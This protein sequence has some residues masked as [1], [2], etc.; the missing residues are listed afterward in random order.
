[1]K[2][3]KFLGLISVLSGVC[4]ATSAYGAVS[5]LADG[6]SAGDTYTYEASETFF[7]ELAGLNREFDYVTAKKNGEKV[8]FDTKKVEALTVYATDNTFSKT[9]QNK[10]GSGK[11]ADKSDETD[12]RFIWKNGDKGLVWN[13]KD[14]SVQYVY[15]DGLAAD[16]AKDYYVIDVQIEGVTDVCTVNVEVYGK[17]TEGSLSYIDFTTDE[18]KQKLEKTR[19]AVQDAVDGEGKKSTYSVPTAVFDVVNSEFYSRSELT[20]YVYSAAPGSSFNSGSSSNGSYS[21]ISTSSAGEYQF[22]VLYKDPA[23]PAAINEITTKDL[24]RKVGELGLGWY[25]D[26]DTLKIPI[27]VF[28]YNKNQAIGIETSGGGEGFVNYRYKDLGITVTNGS[29]SNFKLEFKPEGSEDFR[30]AVNKKDA[31]FDIDSFSTS[32]MNF[33]PL[34]KGAFRVTC[35]VFGTLSDTKEIATTNVVTVTREYRQVKLV[36]ERFKTFWQNNWKS[37]IFLGIAVLSLIGIVVVLCYKPKE[38]AVAVG[39]TGRKDIET[40]DVKTETPEEGAVAEDAT[41]AETAEDVS[42]EDNAEEAEVV[43]EDAGEATGTEA[44]VTEADA[45]EEAETPA[46]TETPAPAEETAET[47]AEENKD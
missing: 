30:E 29:A 25:D 20:S 19:T 22:Y 12:K 15:N 27:F 47:P 17:A 32:S 40:L 26:A 43:E 7:R 10:L 31:E 16:G 8:D 44:P 45:T 28:T 1:M 5:A 9:E 34:K 14:C 46:E 42:D 36:D 13:T 2:S 11:A 37:M 33:T 4:I 23:Y 38:T 6:E 39:K 24:T 21:S 18:G 3:K 35:E 41:D